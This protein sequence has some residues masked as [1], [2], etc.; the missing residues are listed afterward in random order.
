MKRLYSRMAALFL[1]IL[2]MLL[3]FEYAGRIPP[4]GNP[5]IDE[6]LRAFHLLG[7]LEKYQHKQTS[8]LPGIG[9]ILSIAAVLFIAKRGRS[10]CP[11][12]GRMLQ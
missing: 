1:P 6:Y 3:L 5:H 10:F 7:E 2:A 4:S 11:E 9:E 8:F 12:S